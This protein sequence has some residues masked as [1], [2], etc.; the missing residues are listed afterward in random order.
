DYARS[1]YYLGEMYENGFG[2]GKNTNTAMD[3]Y[4]LALAGG[5]SSAADGIER[6]KT[7]KKKKPRFL[8]RPKVKPDARQVTKDSVLRG[9]WTKRNKPVE[10]L[11]SEITDC[12]SKGA[13]IECLSK[14]I[15]R[16]IGMADITYTT[17]AVIFS[18]TGDN[19]FKIS[20]RNNVSKIKVTDEDFAESGEPVP[21]KVGW[22]DAEH[23]LSC[24]LENDKSVLC[25]KNRLRKVKLTR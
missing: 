23:T 18:F 24:E 9:G 6:I 10:Y 7:S 14:N 20:Y 17:K 25:T 4:K 8:K 13:K 3:W 22:Q 11:P 16:N 19:L 1:Q 21:V 15:T 2:V 12:K 5:Y